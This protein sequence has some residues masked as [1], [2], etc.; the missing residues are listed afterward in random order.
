MLSSPPK[1]HLFAW[2]SIRT[3]LLVLLI[4]IAG[5]LVFDRAREIGA[6]RE[7]E[8]ARATREIF[9]TAQRGA[10]REA[11]LIA[12]ARA[13]LTLA[14]RDPAIEN[15]SPTACQ[16][17]FQS[18]TTVLPLLDDM[19]VISKAGG[20]VCTSSKM[21]T[22]RGIADRPYFRA[23]MRTREFA[24]S[25][26]LTSRLTSRPVVVAAMP[27]LDGGEV[28]SILLASINADWFTRVARAASGLE[29]ADVMLINRAGDVVSTS[30]RLTHWVGR[31]LA[32]SSDLW[33]KLNGPDGVIDTATLDGVERI[34]GHI[35]LPGTKG[36]LLVMRSHEQVL[37]AANAR[38]WRALTTIFGIG[39]VCLLLVWFG[40]RLFILQPLEALGAAA[41][42]LGEGDLS[43]HVDTRK[44]APELATLGEAFNS[45][46]SLLAQREEELRTANAR[47][48]ELAATDGL[49]G[50]ANKRQFKEQLDVEW[51]RAI[52][53]GTP[54]ALILLD[55]DH[56][57]KFNDRYG[58]IAGDEC[59]ERVAGAL[60]KACRRP[61]DMAAR[62]GGEEFAVLL[63]GAQMEDAVAIAESV[64]LAIRSLRIPHADSATGLITASLG[65][66]SLMPS[67][68]QSTLVLLNAAD[69]ALYR[70]KH[71]GRN[72]VMLHRPVALAS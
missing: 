61:G 43:T 48:A 29:T 40:G 56:F 6:E 55:V 27:R 32:E 20:L 15:D 22:S 26:F 66:A 19:S 23:V 38:A 42:R 58:H 5:F 39:V 14:A 31:S 34:I 47:L 1:K 60:K 64:R 72:R 67:A 8:I 54:V 45:M 46:S 3:Q 62:T 50:I 65:V 2:F 57:K 33:A 9:T 49:T 41:R 68:G 63:P 37:G 24:I 51:R 10:Q 44:L 71:H 7:R 53:S 13:V 12:S 36:L 17:P 35:R 30:T 18:V 69:S 52:R 28:V 11:E 59:L 70:A 25:D 16:A 21:T 4:G